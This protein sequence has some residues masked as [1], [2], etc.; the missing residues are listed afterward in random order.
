ME[1]RI[2]KTLLPYANR[3][4]S[5]RRIRHVWMGKGVYHPRSEAF[6]Q[7]IEQAADDGIITDEE[8]VRLIVTDM[9]L[10]SQ[11]KSDKSTLWLAV[12]GAGVIKYRD[13]TRAKCSAIAIAKIYEQ[14]ALPFVYG[15]R[16][17]DEQR[18]LASR[19][20]VSILLDPDAD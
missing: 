14:D 6:R 4:F 8:E 16:I 15:F 18:E 19:L 13:I 1:S 11:R 9:V 17:H 7:K 5:V 20:Q 2:S 10:H 3:K 12:Q